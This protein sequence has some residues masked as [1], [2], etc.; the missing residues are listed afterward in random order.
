EVPVIRYE[1]APILNCKRSMICVCDQLPRGLHGQAKIAKDHPVL[2]AWRQDSTVRTRLQPLDE[3]ERDFNGGRLRPDSS[4]GN[5][6]GKA[7][8]NERRQRIRRSSLY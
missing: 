7:T 4:M 3:F 6:P 2:R 1:F 5:D 8:T